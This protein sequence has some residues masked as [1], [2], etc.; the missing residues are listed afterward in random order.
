MNI[1]YIYSHVSLSMQERLLNRDFFFRNLQYFYKLS[2]KMW[3]T[4]AWLSARSF[5]DFLPG[6][7]WQ[8]S[9]LRLMLDFLT[10]NFAYS[11]KN[12]SLYLNITNLPIFL[13]L[14]W[15]HSLGLF[16]NRQFFWN[17]NLD[18]FVGKVRIYLN[19]RIFI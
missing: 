19:L 12:F 11:V 16:R 2:R 9:Y 13:M 8:I 14:L 1:M 7:F 5:A 10:V 18:I 3:P 4:A 15:V 17:L 6:L